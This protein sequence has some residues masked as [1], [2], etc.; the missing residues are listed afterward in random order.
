MDRDQQRQLIAKHTAEFLAAGN[1]VALI[2]S[3][4]FAAR[5]DGTKRSAAENRARFSKLLTADR[6]LCECKTKAEKGI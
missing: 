6:K 5:E 2:P 3:D 4:Q 1:A